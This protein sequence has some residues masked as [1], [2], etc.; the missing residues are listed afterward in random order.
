MAALFYLLRVSDHFNSKPWSEALIIYKS[1]TNIS[2]LLKDL[3]AAGIDTT[4]T[5]LTTLTDRNK[6]ILLG[7]ILAKWEGEL[8][9]GGPNPGT[10]RQWS[11]AWDWTNTVMTA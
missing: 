10:Q 3:E 9:Y 6:A 8:Y 2:S 7:A 11:E 4:E 1:S 5:V